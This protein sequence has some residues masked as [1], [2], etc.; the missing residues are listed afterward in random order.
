MLNAAGRRALLRQP[1]AFFTRRLASSSESLTEMVSDARA[2]AEGEAEEAA[3]GAEAAAIENPRTVTV[4]ERYILG[5]Y[6]RINS[7]C[8]LVRGP[9]ARGAQRPLG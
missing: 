1:G 4:K 3:S 7:L 2:G 6:K 5:S 9:Q 8:T